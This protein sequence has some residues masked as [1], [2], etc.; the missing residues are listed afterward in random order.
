M[1]F[2]AEVRRSGTTSVLDL[3]GDIDAQADEGLNTAY[4]ESQQDGSSSVVLNF[5]GVSYMN[6]TGIALI[7]SL[8]AQARKSGTKVLAIGLTDHYRE[9]FEITR[10]A[11]FVEMHPDE[12]SALAST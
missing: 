1:A 9:I 8:L 12:A 11:D 3:H 10:V 6:S 5:A 2:S 7:V 4:T